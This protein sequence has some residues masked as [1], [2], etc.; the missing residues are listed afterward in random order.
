MGGRGS[1]SRNYGKMDTN[2]NNERE[3]VLSGGVDTQLCW[4]DVKKFEKMINN[5]AI[6]FNMTIHHGS[7]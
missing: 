4:L 7:R 3:M 1:G 6:V 5:I 2:H